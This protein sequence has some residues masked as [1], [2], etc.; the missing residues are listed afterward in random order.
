[1]KTMMLTISIAM[2]MMTMAS[3]VL[4]RPDALDAKV[5]ASLQGQGMGK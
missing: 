1:M 4:A 3:L 2:L 5:I